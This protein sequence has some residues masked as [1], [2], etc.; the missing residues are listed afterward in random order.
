[1]TNALSNHALVLRVNELFHDLEGEEYAG[2]HPEIFEQEKRRWE[3]ILA[4]CLPS[5]SAPR[6]F[7]DVGSGTGFVGE[8]LMSHMRTGDMF[9][10][11]DISAKMLNICAEKFAALRPNITLQ[12]A[13]MS[14]EAIPIPDESVDVLTMNSVLHHMPDSHRFLLECARV[15][16]PGGLLF[17]GH[18]PNKRFFQSNSFLPAQAS[19]FHHLAPRKLLVRIVRALGIYKATTAHHSDP[20]LQHINEVLV[21][22]KLIEQPLTHADLS[23]L[24]DVHS[25][26]AGGLR[27]E[28]GFDPLSV[29]DS[30]PFNVRTVQ[31]YNHLSKIS[32]KHLWLW[33]YEKLLNTLFPSNGA[34]FFL[35]AQ[36]I[37]KH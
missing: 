20:F 7:L 3:N 16:K 4:T 19:L 31:T 13:K 30:L 28:E 12:T 29:L 17:I 1:M 8:R 23:R 6:T 27:R 24:L 2:V 35:V 34:T 18:E 25:P 15:L 22:E 26:T 9:I 36:K 5:S 32:G 21:R 33:P 11:A 14:S 37:T 10:C